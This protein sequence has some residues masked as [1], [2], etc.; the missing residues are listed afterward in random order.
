MACAGSLFALLGLQQKLV[1][2]LSEV[3]F[4]DSSVQGSRFAVLRYEDKEWN[5][6]HL[7]ESG[8]FSFAIHIHFVEVHFAGI[9]LGQLFEDGSHLTA[10]AAPIGIEVDDGRTFAKELPIFLLFVVEHLGK[11][12]FLGEFD[13]FAFAFGLFGGSGGSFGA[14]LSHAAG[15]QDCQQ[16][17]YCPLFLHCDGVFRGV[18]TMG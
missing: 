13:Y 7:E 14:I 18:R 8:Q 9:F 3:V 1:D 15:R 10:R 16:Q 4:L 11:K 6:L 17:G 5:A 12:Y 2:N